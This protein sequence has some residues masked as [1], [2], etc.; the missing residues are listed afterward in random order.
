M[1]ELRSSLDV[2]VVGVEGIDIF[3]FFP[4]QFVAPFGKRN[5]MDLEERAGDY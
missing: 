4:S 2:V 1:E 5:K 3:W